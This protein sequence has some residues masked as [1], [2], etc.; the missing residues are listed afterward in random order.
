MKRDFLWLLALLTA[1]SLHG[2]IPRRANPHGSFVVQR[3][4]ANWDQLEITVDGRYDPP[5]LMAKID[6][7][8]TKSVVR[9]LSREEYLAIKKVTAELGCK[10]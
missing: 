10:L 1:A 5:Y 2:T 4:Q 8:N 3:L 7:E 6:G 9:K